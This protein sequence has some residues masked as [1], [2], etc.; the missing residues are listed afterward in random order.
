VKDLKKGEEVLQSIPYDTVVL[1]FGSWRLKS[2]NKIEFGSTD[3]FLATKS[4]SDT[5]LLFSIIYGYLIMIMP[6]KI[7]NNN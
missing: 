4:L 2:K 3:I 1:N 7:K 6:Q 5:T